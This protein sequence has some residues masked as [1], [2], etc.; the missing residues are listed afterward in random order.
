MHKSAEMTILILVHFPKNGYN[1]VVSL[2][3]SGYNR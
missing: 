1:F 3:L 2:V